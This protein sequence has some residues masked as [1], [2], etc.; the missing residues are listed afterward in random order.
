VIC[1][2]SYKG[3]EY[4]LKGCLNDA[5]CMKYLLVNRFGFPESSILMLTGGS[6]ASQCKSWIMLNFY[7]FY[8][9]KVKIKSSCDVRQFL[10]Y[11]IFLATNAIFY[12]NKKI[13]I[14][15]MFSTV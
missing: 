10:C 7:L 2:I 1:G 11:D 15:K 14:V 3:T 4:E 9:T 5:N 12:G 6:S 13:K 8:H